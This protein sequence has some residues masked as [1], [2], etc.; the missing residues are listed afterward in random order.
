[1]PVSTTVL[2][3]N[4]L[5]IAVTRSLGARFLEIQRGL[6]MTAPRICFFG[7]FRGETTTLTRCLDSVLPLVDFVHITDTRSPDESDEMEVSA[8]EW[9]RRNNIATKVEVS[10]FVDFGVSRS[11]SFRLARLSFPDARYYLTMDAD[12]VMVIEDGFDKRQL[13]EAVYSL[14]QQSSF[15]YRN[16]RLFR[17]DVSAKAIGSTHE[18]WDVGGTPITPLDGLHIDDL[19]DGQYRSKKFTRDI[20]LLTR[21]LHE[22]RGNRWRSMFYLGE[23][24]RN[25]A[26]SLSGNEK[27]T[28]L[29]IALQYYQMVYRSPEAWI[30]ERY[31]A[32]IH[33]A[34]IYADLGDRA[35]AIQLYTEAWMLSPR[36]PDAPYKLADYLTFAGNTGRD[37]RIRAYN[38]VQTALKTVSKGPVGG[39]V[40]DM[41]AMTWGFDYIISVC[42]YYA[43]EYQEGRRAID[44]IL[45]DQTV[46]NH[47]RQACEKNRGFYH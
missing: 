26:V 29:N 24:H 16:M 13:T 28:T 45:D 21:D 3:E 42:A 40:H 33:S 15:R 27:T 44:V 11:E 7:I 22:G 37:D 2:E 17:C 34:K 38:V 35:E 5:S 25:H 14:I 30:A 39:I 8:I 1:M 41:V 10:E 9:G 23:S 43:G 31:G 36:A 6:K 4:Q 32:L 19:A 46:P 47:V 18:Y 12:M 20:Q